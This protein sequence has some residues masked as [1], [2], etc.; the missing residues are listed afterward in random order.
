[1]IIVHSKIYKYS[2]GLRKMAEEIKLGSSEKKTD[3]TNKIRGNPWI[4][5]TVVFA[6]IA[7]ILLVL[8]FAGGITGNVI[9]EKNIGEKAVEFINSQ[10]LQGQGTVTLNS[11]NV[12]GGLYEV[13]VT[14]NGQQIPAY[15]TKDGAYYAGTQL[16]SIT[17]N[18]VD[19]TQT[20]QT[21]EVPK[22][23]KPKVELFIMSYCP[24]GTQAE[25]AVI[26]AVQAL[27]NKIDFNVRFVH[28]TMHGEKE[29]TENFRQLCIREEH[30]SQFL[31][32]LS[33]FLEAGDATSCLTKYNLNVD[34]CVAGKAKDYY[35]ADSA[36]SQNYGVQGSPT[37]IINGVET[38]FDR[39]PA[40]ALVAICSAFNT[41]PSECSAKLSTSAE[42]PGFGSSADT[43]GHAA[44]DT[45]CGA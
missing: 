23:D 35:A 22:T 6:V 2:F 9:S 21:T 32:Y 1:M 17:G 26:P 41:A 31:N 3:L 33:C 20:Q 24:Y 16:Y 37:L 13:I 5:S 42:S 28:Y 8:S 25:K 40:E 34:S 43:A 7:I 38:S 11:I 10:L 39:S 19:N 45:T 36:L 15:F 27:G 44:S 14:Y 12:K 30:N 18:A 29:D 4:I